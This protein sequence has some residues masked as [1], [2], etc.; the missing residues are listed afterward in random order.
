M[1]R[2]EP[3]TMPNQ[4]QCPVKLEDVDLFSRGAQEHWYEAYPI[5]HREAPVYKIPGEGLTPENDGYVLTR[6]EDIRRIVDDPVK[7]NPG[8]TVRPKPLPD[9]TMPQMNAMMV[10]IQTLRPNEDLWRAHKAEL[11]DPWVGAGATRHEAMITAAATQLIDNWID[12]GKVDFVNEFARPLPQMVMANVLGFPREDIPQLE[13]W[14]GAQVMAF[15]HG[16]TH[17]NLLTPEQ[18]AE[19]ISILQGFADYVADKVVEKRK[20]PQDDMISWLTQVTYSPLNRKLT[21]VEING[22][23]YAMVIGGLETTQYALAEEAQL[24]CEDPDLYRTVRSDRTHLRNFIEESLRLR[25]PTQGLSTRTLEHED[26]FQGVKMKPG[27]I[28][29]LRW[30]AANRDPKE[31]ECPHDL[32]LD[33]EGASRHLAFSRGSRS[34]PGQS[35]SRVEQRIA[36]NLLMDRIEHLE[37]GEG[38]TFEHQPGIMLG[39]YRLN[40]NFRKAG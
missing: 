10:A 3:R 32:K 13:K 30:A 31:W 19:Q 24:F 23:V 33:R 14:G 36:W 9:G 21:D 40:L 15:V 26:E 4:M 37:Y 28:L 7:Y 17:R 20:R 16:H 34:C 27:D 11:T 35:L 39:L 5:L 29:H 25:S 1:A 18:M 22:I 8:L 2:T 6:Y 38:N 12:N